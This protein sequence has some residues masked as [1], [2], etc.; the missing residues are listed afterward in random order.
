MLKQ[1][2]VLAMSYTKT[3]KNMRNRYDDFNVRSITSRLEKALITS[4][5]NFQRP[6]SLH[7]QN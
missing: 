7:G 3:K 2:N 1:G 5:K 6:R 4:D